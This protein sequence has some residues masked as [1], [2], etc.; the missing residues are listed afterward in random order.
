MFTSE[1]GLHVV[2]TEP[3]D[4][5]RQMRQV[6]AA[7]VAAKRRFIEDF[8]DTPDPVT[9]PDTLRLT[10]EDLEMAARV[11]AAL[12]KFIAAKKLDGLAYYYEGEEG[13]EM[14]R[15]VSNFI[16]GNSMLCAAGFS[17]VRRERSEDLR[18]AC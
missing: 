7:E 17:H 10:G 16:M 4:V 2:L 8:F 11:A 18:G 6:T 12:D 14:R 15:L 5:M 1:F 13:S 9:D 3:D